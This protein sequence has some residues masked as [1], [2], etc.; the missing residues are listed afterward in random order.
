MPESC[1]VPSVNFGTAFVVFPFRRRVKEG[2][3]ACSVAIANVAHNRTMKA[4]CMKKQDQAVTA[5]TVAKSERYLRSCK[6]RTKREMIL[7]GYILLA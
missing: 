6:K 1:N 5:R 3:L 2:V 4:V 7:L